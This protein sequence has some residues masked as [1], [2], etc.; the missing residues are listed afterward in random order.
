MHYTW[1]KAKAKKVLK[2]HKIDFSKIEDIFRD[3]FA[4]EFIDEP[5]SDD[6]EVRFA[7]I[8]LTAE[9]GLT[10]LVFTDDEDQTIRFITAR[11]AERWMVKDY[12]EKR[13]RF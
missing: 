5:H 8:G 13:H 1:D 9:Y 3:P 4:V 7:I 10:H 6:D 12:E 11:K 2:D